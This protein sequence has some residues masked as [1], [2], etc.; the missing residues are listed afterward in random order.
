MPKSTIGL[1]PDSSNNT[2]S[3]NGKSVVMNMTESVISVMNISA[4]TED[5]DYGDNNP[6]DMDRYFRYSRDGKIWSMWYPWTPFADDVI[7]RRSVLRFNPDDE[8]YFS[9]KYEY[10]TSMSPETGELPTPVVVKSIGI[11]IY[12]EA[13]RYPLRMDVTGIKCF[14]DSCPENLFDKNSTLD[15]YDIGP[16]GDFYKSMSYSMNLMAGLQ[17]CY[18]HTSPDES[19]TDYIFREYTLYNMDSRKCIKAVVPDNEFGNPEFKYMPTDMSFANE[20]TL[21]L[22]IDKVYFEEFFGRR[23]EPRKKDFLYMPIINRMYE[24][25]DVEMVR[26]LMMMPIYWEL[27]LRKFK[28][29][30]NQQWS[31]DANRETAELLDNMILTSDDQFG[32]EAAY[33]EKNAIVESQYAMEG[34]YKKPGEPRYFLDQALNVRETEF[35]FNYTRLF[36]YYYDMG[37]VLNSAGL[38]VIYND[39]ATIDKDNGVTIMFSFQ[40]LETTEGEQK[41][42]TTEGDEPKLNICSE[43]KK[44]AYETIDGKKTFIGWNDVKFWLDLNGKTYDMSMDLMRFGKWYTL[45]V[46][47]M[48]QFSQVGMYMYEFIPDKYDSMNSSKVNLML[49]SLFDNCADMEINNKKRFA[50][51]RCI[52]NVANFRVFN[53]SIDEEKHEYVLSQLVIKDEGMLRVIDNCRPKLGMPFIMKKY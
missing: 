35:N 44:K 53:R 45:M 2:I 25:I 28:P 24:V 18:F 41:F 37:S 42:V 15:L 19:G 17:V 16:M 27:S 22:N 6:D 52:A 3:F 32:E 31:L 47:I 38:G 5:I 36:N 9:F 20:D 10:F 4:I 33:Q 50:L 30:I 11:V 12:T 51:S 21:V 46:C 48:P 8:L 23:A 34:E 13:A 14:G 26:G 43:V 49:H 40:L 1:V 7:N 29:N 39:Y